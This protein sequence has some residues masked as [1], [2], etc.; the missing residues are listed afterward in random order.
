MRN[1]V[2]V[3]FFIIGFVLLIICFVFIV[4]K[5]RGKI[6]IGFGRRMIR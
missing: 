5:L 4:D 6:V 1:Y 2:I 3:I